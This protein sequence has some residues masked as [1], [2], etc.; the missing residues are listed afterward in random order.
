V[1]SDLVRRRCQQLLLQMP[2][3]I[4]EDKQLQQQQQLEGYVPEGSGDD[5]GLMSAV[6][7]YRMAKKQLLHKIAE[8]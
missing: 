5:G 8:L 4:Q 3:S 6:L 2:T 7:Q 1:L